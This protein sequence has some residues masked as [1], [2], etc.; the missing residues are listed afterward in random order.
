MVTQK[1]VATACGVSESAVSAAFLGRRHIA[2]KKRAE[3][4][5]TA[6][7]MGYIAKRLHGVQIGILFPNF[8]NYY[9]GEYFNRIVFG[10]FDMAKQLGVAIQIFETFPEDYET[11]VQLAGLIL[12]GNPL[13]KD[14]ELAN[15]YRLPTVLCGCPH[16]DIDTHQVLV[17]TSPAIELL[18]KYVWGSGHRQVAILTGDHSVTAKNFQACVLRV[19]NPYPGS[20]IDTFE[21]DYSDL[22]SLEPTLLNLIHD[23]RQFTC[24]MCSSDLIA[25]YVYKICHK[26]GLSIP[27]RLSITGFDGIDI[28]RFMDPPLPTLTTAVVDREQIGREALQLLMTVLNKPPKKYLSKII[29]TQ[30]IVGNSVRNQ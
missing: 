17:Q 8:R 25:L 1:E 16:E 2:A 11:A 28:P 15:R 9:F 5:K 30:L 29:S 23:P 12:F 10:I 13:P 22:Q 6:K 21:A 18:A 19:S 26:M 20:V 7:E 3:I 27:D 24:V 14:Y 4:L